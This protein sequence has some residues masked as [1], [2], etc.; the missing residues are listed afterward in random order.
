[1]LILVLGIIAF[2]ALH[3]IPTEPDLRSGLVSRFGEATYKVVF[4]LLSL[5]ALAVIVLGYHKLQLHPGKNPIIWSPPLWLRHVSL[6]L[7]LASMILLV[8]AYIPS[9]IRTAVRHPMLVAV[10]LW[11]L[12]HLLSN[13]DLGGMVLFASFL[14]YAVYDRISVK[15]RQALG[16]LGAA[17]GGMVG[18]I[19]VIVVGLALYVFL[20]FY[21][22]T[23]LIGKSPLPGISLSP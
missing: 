21:G 8:A 5:A 12:A 4:S 6:A 20:L 11:A 13:G 14:A 1:M 18:D 3:L 17:Q 19:A 10:K 2:L 15:K 22:H 23:L 9:R 7:M 16:P